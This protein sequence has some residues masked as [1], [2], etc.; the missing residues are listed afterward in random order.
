M[1]ASEAN[2]HIND[3]DEAFAFA[4][5]LTSLSLTDLFCVLYSCREK[6][7]F[8]SILVPRTA[9]T[10]LCVKEL[11]KSNLYVR[12]LFVE[13]LQEALVVRFWCVVVHFR[14]DVSVCSC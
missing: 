8:S 9:Y 4:L 12:F 1:C 13:S 10:H 11:H 3:C 5:L 6:T 7:H 14:V 2:A